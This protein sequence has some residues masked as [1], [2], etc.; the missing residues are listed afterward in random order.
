M[1]KN[2]MK[3]LNEKWTVYHRIYVF[4]LTNTYINKF[5]TAYWQTTIH[6]VKQNQLLI[7]YK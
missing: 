6:T 4:I 7:E 2:K 3:L 1:H 5:L